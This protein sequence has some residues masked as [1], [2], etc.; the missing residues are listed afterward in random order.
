MRCFWRT[1]HHVMPRRIETVLVDLS[2]TLHI[3]DSA[4][5]GALEALTRLRD[6]NVKLKFVTNTTKEPLRLLHEKLMQIGFKIEKDEIFTSLTAARNLVT[7]RGLRPFLLL[8]ESAKEDFTGVSEENPNAVVVGLAP[9]VFKYDVLNDAFRLLLDG[10]PLIAI[11]KGR[12]YRKKDGLYLGPGPFVTGLEYAAGVTSEVVGKPE[13][14]FFHAAIQTTQSEP[15]TTVM[16]G[17][18]VR[19]D[20]AGAMKAGLLGIL[21]KT[22]KYREGDEKT[23]S[24]PP[25]AVCNDFQAAV[26]YLIKNF[27][28]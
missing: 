19:D 11:H 6:S 5:P 2:G 15:T 21:V 25:T 18:D 1:L 7:G 24:P 23:I 8:E 28:S 16:I 17:D 22:G 10:A 14:A 4:I 26:D 20:V 12:Y 27:L 13:A 3:E 9:N